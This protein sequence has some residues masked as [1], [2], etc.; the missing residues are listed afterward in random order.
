MVLYPD[1]QEKVF[2]EIDRVFGGRDPSYADREQL[3]Y[4]NAT[5][6]EVSRY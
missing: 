3:P 4:T 5:I 2:E 6:L 1:V